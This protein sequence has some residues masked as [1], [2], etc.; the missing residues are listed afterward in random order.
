MHLRDLDQLL[1]LPTLGERRH[2]GLAGRGV[3][4]CRR[5]ILV[6][7]QEERPHPRRS[8]GCSI[9]EEDAA[10]DNAIGEHV[11]IVVIPVAGRTRSDAR[12][13]TR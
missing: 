3:A 4:V 10:D 13:R 5:T 8:D 6:V 7:L 1:P 12:L 2:R 9:R 11:E